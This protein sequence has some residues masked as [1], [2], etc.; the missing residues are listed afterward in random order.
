MSFKKEYAKLNQEQ[1]EA[2]E[3]I[4]GPV[5]VL[6]GP[7]TG[8]TQLLAVRTAN[9]IS[10]TDTPAQAILCLTFT[11]AAAHNLKQRIIEL[12]GKDGQRVVV[13]TFHGFAAEIMNQYPDEFWNA[14]RLEPAPDAVQLQIIQD[15]VAK[16]PLNNPL[17]L[18]FAGQFTLIKDI[19]SALKLAKEAGLTPQKLEAVLDVNLAYIDE[20][21]PLLADVLEPRISKSR[22]EVIAKAI[23]KLPDIAAGASIYPLVPL[24][25]AIKQSFEAAYDEYQSSGKTTPLSK[26]KSGLVKKVDGK[27]G[28]HDERKRNLW[29]KALAGVYKK[30]R[31]ELHGQGYFD[32]SDMVIQVISQLEQNAELRADVQERFLYVMID[33]FQDTNEAQLRLAHLVADHHTAEN[34]PNLMVV[35]DDDQSIFKFQGAELNNMVNFTKQYPDTKMIVLTDN[36][37][38]T[39]DVIDTADK[40]IAQSSYRVVDTNEELSKELVAAENKQESSITASLYDTQEEQYSAVARQAKNLRDSQPEGTIAILARQ[41]DSLVQISAIL[42][43]LDVPIRYE[44]RS[45][46]LKHPVLKQ[47]MTV[48]TIVEAISK[49]DRYSLD[50]TL[51]SNINHPMWGLSGRKLWQVALD[52]RTDGDWLSYLSDSKDDQLEQISQWLYWLVEMSAQPALVVVE[53]ILGIRPFEGNNYLSDYFWPK[54]GKGSDYIET[55]SA[56]QHLRTLIAEYTR[57]GDFSLSDV[58]E[59]LQINLDNEVV[60]TDESPFVSG[61]N[62]INL[63]TVYKA[64]GLEFDTVFIIDATEKYWSPSNR[65]RKPPLNLPLRPAGED[66]D[67]YIRLM[68]V[69]ATRAKTNLKLSTYKYSSS[70]QEVLAAPMAIV[71]FSDFKPEPT[72]NIITVLE[73]NLVW[74]RLSGGDEK[75]MLRG[76]LEGYQLSVTHLL[77]F[78]DLTRGGPEYF[79]QRN[80]LRLPSAKSDKASFGSAMH[81][82]LE[83]AQHLVNSDKFSLDKVQDYFLRALEQEQLPKD[84]K[85]RYQSHGKLVLKQLFNLKEFKLIKNGQAERKIND[86]HLGEAVINGMLD[87]V[88]VSDSGVLITDYKT[89]SPLNKLD[90]RSK[91][92]GLKAFKHRTQLEFYALMA[93]NTPGLNKGKIVCQMTY[94]EAEYDSQLNRQLEP[95]QEDIDKL[96]RL[97]GAVWRAIVN[98]DLPDTSKYSQ[99]LAGVEKFVEDL[100]AG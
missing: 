96:A 91:A 35:G 52:N 87:R 28:M 12:T 69:A 11:N 73:E 21:E 4:D 30:Y 32:Y 57:R 26:W 51:G 59:F 16:L 14:A 47:L 100:I 98:L 75:L 8:K 79:L 20:V 49:G 92:E 94:V 83:Y 27:L 72:E 54:G 45:N 9:I 22:I 31:Q 1:K 74:P 7:G 6:A 33:E 38:S 37:R 84:S 41:H 82:A 64:K 99:D 60:I 55:L 23:H 43:Q 34:R 50:V 39:Q 56:I 53:S 89:G 15:I 10:K 36:Y 65:G 63:M 71:A 18:K 13:K 48:I 93:Q 58:L 66:L 5:M 77:N 40:L 17:A 90:T 86:L 19:Q 25:E 85:E 88:D 70:G 61:Q 67:D 42:D 62:P 29:W 3:A 24:D 68:Y 78:L 44:R 80:L 46:V 97:V 81:D 76:L 95:S 2:V